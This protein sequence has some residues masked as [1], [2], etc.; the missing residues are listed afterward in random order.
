MGLKNYQPT[1]A[2][3]RFQIGLDYSHLDKKRPEKGLI[4][5]MRKS[6]G[7]NNMGRQTDRNLGGGNK[8]YYRIIDFKRNKRNIPA[9]VE[10]FEYDP[11]RSAN[12]ALLKY[13][14]GERAYILAP[15]GLA[16]G[17]TVIASENAEIV[18]GNAM[19]LSAIP[20]GTQ[21]HNIELKLGAGGKLARSA[22]AFAQ[23]MG[24]ENGYIM[25]RMPSGE[26]RMVNENC[27]ATIG[28]VGNLDYENVSIGKAGKTRH[29]GR[30]PHVRGMAMNPVDHPHGGGE[31]RSKGGNHPQSPTGV[32]AKGFKTRKN[33]RTQRFI[34]KD[35]RK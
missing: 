4:E 21:V 19:P 28:Q 24:R 22:G 15:L 20:M 2:G 31:G 35:R 34:I 23:V 12:I 6:G 5:F 25:L 1:S 29:R 30:R 7:R 33:K 26:T 10:A 18:A 27:W 17:A 32:P 14:D 8:C 16:K 11:N 3:R 9:V 13:V